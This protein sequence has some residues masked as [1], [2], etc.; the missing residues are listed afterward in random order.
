[1]DT[2]TLHITRG[3]LR[4]TAL[5]QARTMHNAFVTEGPQPG[6]EVA[7]SLG[8]V[9]HS[10]YV[11]V[12]GTG[13]FA[14][15]APGELLFVDYWADPGGMETFFSHP[16]A[17]QAGDRLYATREESEW[18]LA[19]AAFT[20]QVPAPAGVTARFLAITRAPVR[21]AADAVAALDKVVSTNLGT[22]RRRGQV[23][24]SVYVRVAELAAARPASNASLGAHRHA[25]P[26][27]ILAVETWPDIEGLTEH[28][29]D[30]TIT[31]GLDDVLSG[32]LDVSVWEQANGFA[33]W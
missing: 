26:V 11:P 3:T 16:S 15:T 31:S 14:D 33:E 10:V 12:P 28:H 24:Q 30:A 21:A 27:E 9:S 5:D 20:F 1:M 13:T 19:P 4:P 32:P 6:A 22:A 25:A 18:T 17:Q 29:R 8:D 2:L 7:R 23:A